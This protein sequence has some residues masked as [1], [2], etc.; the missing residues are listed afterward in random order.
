MG[1]QKQSTRLA[2]LPAIFHTRRPGKSHR[3]PIH[4]IWY[5]FS[6]DLHSFRQLSAFSQ[7]DAMFYGN[8]WLI[9]DMFPA[10][11]ARAFLKIFLS[12]N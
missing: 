11:A 9:I 1:G 7:F 3:I 5:S 6:S 4:T 12:F 10:M 2:I 8:A